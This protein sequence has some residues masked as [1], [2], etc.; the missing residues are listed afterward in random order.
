MR[1]ELAVAV[2]ELRGERSGRVSMTRRSRVRPNQRRPLWSMGWAQATAPP[3]GGP[4]HVCPHT[5]TQVSRIHSGVFA[6]LTRTRCW[7]RSSSKLS[8]PALRCCAHD[9]RAR[10]QPSHVRSH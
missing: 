6:A 5:R 8:S 9:K 1:E 10:G 7:Y 4:A 3:C 2:L